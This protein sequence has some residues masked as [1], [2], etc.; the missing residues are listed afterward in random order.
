M[1]CT[2]EY[3]ELPRFGEI[4]ESSIEQ[5]IKYL[6]TDGLQQE[7]KKMLFN[8]NCPVQILLEYLCSEIGLDQDVDYDL[9]ELST[10]DLVNIKKLQQ[11]SYATNVLKIKQSYAFVIFQKDDFGVYKVF[12]PILNRHSKQCSDILIRFKRQKRTTKRSGSVVKRTSRTSSASKASSR[13]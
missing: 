4:L 10:G 13:R 9:C 8:P 3:I 12:E 1:Y 6:A 7:N 2:L 11:W 5:I